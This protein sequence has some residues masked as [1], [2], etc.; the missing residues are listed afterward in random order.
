VNAEAGAAG[1]ESKTKVAARDA[2]KT[3]LD[4]AHFIDTSIYEAKRAKTMFGK[5][6]PADARD[7]DQILK[8][9]ADLTKKVKEALDRAGHAW[10]LANIQ[11][12]SNAEESARLAW[13]NALKDKG[14]TAGQETSPET[15]AAWA[16]YKKA[17]E[18]NNQGYGESNPG[19][20]SETNAIAWLQEGQYVA[21]YNGI[22]GGKDHWSVNSNIYGENKGGGTSP[23]YRDYNGDGVIDPG[24]KDLP[25]TAVGTGILIHVGDG[26]G[27]SIGCQIAPAN[28][29]DEFVALVNKLGAKTQFRYGLVEAPHLPAFGGGAAP[30]AGASGATTG[31]AAPQ[32]DPKD[33]K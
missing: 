31:G 9:N 23:V 26:I 32:A 4:A 16:A 2:A 17:R 1:A 33:A 20:M 5:K 28:T 19:K 21:R 29:F 22:K 24:E 25:G 15:K 12:S 10:A 13:E 30:A 8:D 6:R 27:Y 7:P 3:A 18:A 11:E 14:E